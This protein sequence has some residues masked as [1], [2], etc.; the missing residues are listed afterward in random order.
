MTI[1]LNADLHLGHDKSLTWENDD[2]TRCR[3]FDTIGGYHETVI[4]NHNLVVKPEDRVYFLGDAVIKKYALD[5]IREFNGK[6]TL[7]AGNHDIFDTKEYLAAG[8]KNVRGV[9]VLTEYS[10]ILSHIPVHPDSLINGKVGQMTNYHGHLHGGIVQLRDG[11]PDLRYRCVSVEHT[12]YH[13]YLL[14]LGN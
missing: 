3:P 5:L 6:K 10:V 13:P 2:G 7:I 4:K 14:T 8:F 11:Y 12:N 9:R 1:W